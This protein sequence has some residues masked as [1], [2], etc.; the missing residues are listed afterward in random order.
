MLCKVQL[1]M[2]SVTLLGLSL[3][4]A[5]PNPSVS[6]VLSFHNYSVNELIFKL[7]DCSM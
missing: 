1:H 4:T 2:I 5:V 3:L 6:L 7:D